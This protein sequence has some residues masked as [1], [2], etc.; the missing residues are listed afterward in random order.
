MISCSRCLQALATGSYT[1]CAV[2]DLVLHVSL[3]DGTEVTSPA[4]PALC[5]NRSSGRRNCSRTFEARVS[6]AT[7]MTS[8]NCCCKSR[9]NSGLVLLEE[10]VLSSSS[11]WLAAAN[12]PSFLWGA[13]N[14]SN[15][16]GSRACN[17]VRATCG[18]GDRDACVDAS[19]VS[20]RLLVASR[21]AVV[22]SSPPSGGGSGPNGA[23]G[24]KARPPQPPSQRGSS[25]R[26][27]RGPMTSL[28]ALGNPNCVVILRSASLRPVQHMLW[29]SSSLFTLPNP[30]VLSS[31]P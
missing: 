29:P 11:P 3:F 22:D 26:A 23:A 15:L 13:V 19:S 6:C 30:I 18:A 16:R 9:C 8:C 17:N 4:S 25:P 31:K 2:V 28:L 10:G 24:R 1:S 7:H 12:L 14:S 21:L 5:C 27:V 20:N